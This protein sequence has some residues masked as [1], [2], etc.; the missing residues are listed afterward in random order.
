MDRDGERE[1]KCSRPRSTRR[2][3]K[4]WIAA[5]V[6]IDDG[7]KLN[8]AAS[9]IDDVG[10]RKGGGRGAGDGKRKRRKSQ[11]VCGRNRSE[12]RIFSPRGSRMALVRS[13]SSSLRPR[14]AIPPL[15]LH[16]PRRPLLFPAA[17]SRVSPQRARVQPSACSVADPLRPPPLPLPAVTGGSRLGFG[18]AII[19]IPGGGGEGEER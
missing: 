8:G 12:W 4:D 15:P 2:G 10:G 11:R 3:R 16:R 7:G 19:S 13:H 14:E 6:G 5:D 18:R 9:N 1:K 17:A